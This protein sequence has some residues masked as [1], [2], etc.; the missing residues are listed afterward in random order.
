MAINTVG[1]LTYYNFIRASNNHFTRHTEPGLEITGALTLGCWVRFDADSTG[2]V[3]GVLSKWYETGNQRAFA[4]YKAADNSLNFSIS[5][6]GTA[7]T[8]VSDGA[9]N[10]A[11]S[12]WFFVAGRFTPSSELALFVNRN[13]YTNVAAIPASIFNSS[14]AFEVGRYNRTNYLDGRISRAVL[15]AYAIA[16]KKIETVY[17]HS[18]ALY[19]EHSQM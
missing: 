7:V 10:Y 17:A 6:D 12:K 5:T 3:T 9:A 1:L 14:E 2:V 13:W 19:L 18:A 11:A 16:N 4:I 8:S 15:C